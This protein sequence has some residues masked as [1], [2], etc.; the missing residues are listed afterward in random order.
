M[1]SFLVFTG[2]VIATVAI[3]AAAFKL[4]PRAEAL[5]KKVADSLKEASAA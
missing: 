3:G 4:G 1:K 2:T 5:N